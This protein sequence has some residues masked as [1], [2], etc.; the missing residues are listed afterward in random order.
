MNS[1]VIFDSVSFKIGHTTILEQIT[2]D[3]Q[4]GDITGI[5]GPNGA[6]KSTLL[7]LINGLH[8]HSSGN[9]ILLD[10]QLPTK[11]TKIRQ[12]IGVVLQETAL[13]EE[14]TTFENLRFSASLYSVQNAT[15]RI[16][17]VLELLKLT[18]R[19]DQIV[20][21]LSGGLRRR[22]AIAR[23][24]IHN[25][26]LLIIDEPT[27]GV[28]AQARHAIWQ[29]LRL[30]K[31]K[32]RTVI[33]ATNYL[34]E[35]QAL[36]DTVAVLKEGKLLAR[37]TPEE[38]VSRAGYCLDISCNEQECEKIKEILQKE[39]DVLLVDQTLSGLSVFLKPGSSQEP[40]MDTVLKNAHIEG[41]RVR[42]PDL[43]EVFKALEKKQ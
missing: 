38:L 22:I 23:A 27:L 30:L 12:R 39:T 31:T 14:L 29:H 40:L 11:K 9:I 3:I 43:I 1:A 17:E 32:G 35:A 15:E 18:D 37:E 4:K 21:T 41:F 16:I 6:G 25:P 33:V 34:D 2:L 28:D 10:E 24:L 7:S 8:T 26:E 5:L 42:S 13:Y 20:R 19:A 36:C